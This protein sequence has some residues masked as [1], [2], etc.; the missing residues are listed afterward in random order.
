VILNEKRRA[1]GR[2][3]QFESW[4]QERRTIEDELASG[5]LTGCGC[6]FA[7]ATTSFG[8]LGAYGLYRL[9]F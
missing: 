5:C 4:V 9:L 8:A 2:G 1:E 6:L 7:A 3:Q